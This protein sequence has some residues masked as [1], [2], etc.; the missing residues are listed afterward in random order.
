MQ[1]LMTCLFY[2]NPEDGGDMDISEMLV[3]TN[4][5][6]WCHNSEDHNQHNLE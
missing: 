2:F 5:T 6:T 1:S 3:T 4:K